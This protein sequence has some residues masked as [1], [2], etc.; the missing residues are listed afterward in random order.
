MGC[1][2]RNQP[3]L[4]NKTTGFSLFELLI[5]LTLLVAAVSLVPA[6]LSKGV[7]T[8]ELKSSV[9]QITAGLNLTRSEA[10]SHNSARVFRLDVERR[11]FSTARDKS[12]NA[13]PKALNLKLKTAESEQE[14]EDRGGIRFF[15]D[16]SSTGGEI[17]VATGTREFAVN[18]NWITGK[19]TVYDQGQPTQ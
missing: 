7:S 11:E 16:G 14:T 4:R 12:T 3:R 1:C 2:T 6:Y 8:A 17:R 18:V 19:V 10:I 15:P 5:V 9:R 13:L